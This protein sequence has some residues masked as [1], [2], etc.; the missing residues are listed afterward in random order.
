MGKNEDVAVQLKK[1]VVRARNMG[2]SWGEISHDYDM[3]KRT[4]RDIVKRYRW[5]HLRHLN[6]FFLLVVLF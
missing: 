3:P 4:A 6:Y 1:L 2:K 5:F